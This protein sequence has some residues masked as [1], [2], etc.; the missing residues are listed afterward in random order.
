MATDYTSQFSDFSNMPQYDL[1]RQK[2]TQQAAADKQNNLDTLQRRFANLGN[3][4]SGAQIKQEENLS[5][6]SAKN[7][8]DATQSINAQQQAEILRRQEVLQG[9]QFQGEQ[10]GKQQAFATSERLGNQKFASGERAAGE[11]FAGGQNELQRQQQAEQF[12]KTFGLSKDQMAQ[13][14]AQF[15]K[16]F[17][18][19]V[20]VDKANE[21]FAQ[22]ALDKKGFL[23]GIMG[24]GTSS[25]LATGALG[26]VAPFVSGITK[27]VSSWF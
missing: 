13:S 3:L 4:N 26:P 19:E 7:L 23:D 1:A 20:S 14:Q 6:D 5:N 9:Q 18:E 21:S 16:T 25:P 22:Q 15:D 11:Q 12:M 17:G 2:A 10:L 27:Q 8:S 24:G